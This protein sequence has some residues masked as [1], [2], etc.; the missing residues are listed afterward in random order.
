[1]LVEGLRMSSNKDRNCVVLQSRREKVRNP[2][3]ENTFLSQK[4]SLKKA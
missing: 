3:K 1:M 4:E 2:G